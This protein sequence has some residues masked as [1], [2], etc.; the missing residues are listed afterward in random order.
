MR[1]FRLCI[2]EESH[3]A[4]TAGLPVSSTGVLRGSRQVVVAHKGLGVAGK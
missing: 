3:A 4:P 2:P 1:P